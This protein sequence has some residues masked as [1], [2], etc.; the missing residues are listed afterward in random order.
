MHQNEINIGAPKMCDDF[1]TL[2]IFY[3]SNIVILIVALNVD[4]KKERKTDSKFGRAI[5]SQLRESNQEMKQKM[6][7][8]NKANKI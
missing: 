1:C 2:S 5:A 6:S 8:K 3:C 4:I 7:I